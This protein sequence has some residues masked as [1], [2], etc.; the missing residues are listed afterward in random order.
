M[1][2]DEQHP[3]PRVNI[4]PT[5]PIQLEGCRRMDGGI[6]QKKSPAVRGLEELVSM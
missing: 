6:V 3:Q 4:G 2:V 1:L 5:A